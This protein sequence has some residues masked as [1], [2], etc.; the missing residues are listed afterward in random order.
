[1]R[2]PTTI[3]PAIS[4]AGLAA[5]A[6]SVALPASAAAHGLSAEAADRSTLGFVPTGIEHM[7]LG[8]D[9]LLFVFGVILIAGE[10]RRAAKLISLFA[11]GHSLT[12][13]LATL[14]GWTLSA[15]AVDVVVA[16]SVVM[17][18]VLSI[19]GRPTDWRPIGAG[20]F[21]FG[22]IHGLGL[23]TR[24]HDLGVPDQGLLGKVIAFNVGIELGQLLAI[25]IVSGIAFL[26]INTLKRKPTTK[27]IQAFGAVLV[28]VGLIG[29]SVLVLQGTENTDEN[30][31]TSRID[32]GP[33][34]AAT[35]ENCR[36]TEKQAKNEPGGGHP[37]KL[38][39][40]PGEDVPEQ[41]LAHVV[42]D[43]Y[44]VVRYRPD[45]PATDR[46]ALQKQL[47]ALGSSN[48]GAPAAAGQADAIVVTT[49]ERELR[50]TDQELP[51]LETFSTEWMNELFSRKND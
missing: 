16:F 32:G 48:I 5:C 36:T 2:S 46:A 50:C 15:T 45:L 7:L 4:A 1:V 21:L 20:V 3:R 49:L 27:L 18:G 35:T 26:L 39:Y 30:E 51:V 24:F 29:A 47:D 40:Q 42:G 22:L 9:H 34:A 6:I 43:G 10:V 37:D 31:V 8:W 19:R 41:N 33:A 11:L 28:F 13:I 14:A 38:W 25:G 17:V 12:L 23:A 44:V